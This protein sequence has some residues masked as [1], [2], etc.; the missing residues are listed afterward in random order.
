MPD[1]KISIKDLQR[2]LNSFFDSQNPQREVYFQTNTEG[3]ALDPTVSG[4]IC[5]EEFNHHLQEFYESEHHLNQLLKEDT[6]NRI[7]SL[8]SKLDTQ[9]KIISDLTQENQYLKDSID[10]IL[11]RITDLEDFTGLTAEFNQEFDNN[12]RVTGSEETDTQSSA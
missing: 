8:E 12:L 3:Q 2:A 1:S 7:K 6:P 11:S 9:N 4:P 5:R 10:T